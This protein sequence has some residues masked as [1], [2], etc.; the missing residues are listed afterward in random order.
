M[1]VDYKFGICGGGGLS[2]KVISPM[3][4][5]P[6]KKKTKGSKNVGKSFGNDVG[7]ILPNPAFRLPTFSS[8]I[9]TTSPKK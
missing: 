7:D 4:L 2:N 1:V 8:I 3:T 9:I 5:L 6:A